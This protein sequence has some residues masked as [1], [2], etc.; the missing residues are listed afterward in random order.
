[1]ALGVSDL[2]G[3]ERGL[4]LARSHETLQFVNAARLSQLKTQGSSREKRAVAKVNEDLP[5]RWPVLKVQMPSDGGIASA[6]LLRRRYRERVAVIWGDHEPTHE[7]WLKYLVLLH[8]VM[9]ETVAKAIEEPA[10]APEPEP[11]PAAATEGT[12]TP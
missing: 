11:A 9:R 3:E 2:I 6:E 8:P 12:A 5:L 1:L 10:P 7:D 4:V